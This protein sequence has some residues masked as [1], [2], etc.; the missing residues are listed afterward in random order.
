MQ[1]QMIAEMTNQ[2]QFLI[3]ARKNALM[4]IEEVKFFLRLLLL[5]SC[6]DSCIISCMSLLLG[7][8]KSCS[9]LNMQ[10]YKYFLELSLI[11][12]EKVVKSRKEGIL[13]VIIKKNTEIC[14]SNIC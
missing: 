6:V 10:S 2:Y 7:V 9:I 12:R 1:V 3:Q 11:L 4:G 5:L 14:T 13:V 8:L